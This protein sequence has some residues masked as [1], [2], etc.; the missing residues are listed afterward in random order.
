MGK[1]LGE[2]PLKAS[3]QPQSPLFRAMLL[4]DSISTFYINSVSIQLWK[5]HFL[6]KNDHL[7]LGYKLL[8]P[9]IHLRP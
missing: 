8:L 6:F 2:G 5:I 9:G 1:P 7:S 4:C 3:S